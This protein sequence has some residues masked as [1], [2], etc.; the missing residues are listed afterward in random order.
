MALRPP[1]VKV[2]G[3]TDPATAASCGDL[4]VKAI[5]CVFYAK[6][7]R[8][9]SDALARE[10]CSALPPSIHR[11]GVFVDLSF[12]EIMHKAA[13]CGLTAAQLHGSEPPELVKRLK[14]E[15]ILVIK[16]LFAK[17]APGLDDAEDYA[18]GIF[19]VEQGKGAL[20]GGNAAEWDWG[21]LKGFSRNH[22]LI[23]AGGLKP[24]NVADAIALGQPDAVDVSSGVES[25]PGVKDLAS[26]EAFMTAVTGRPL[27]RRTAR[28]IFSDG[29]DR[30]L[31]D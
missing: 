11:V 9:V 19:L 7:P 1:Q 14:N 13:F 28:P 10:I 23:L 18:D 15:G 5:G 22:P 31:P 12:S 30:T 25:S 4:G 8:F 21:G 3:L 16:A 6:S 26:V 17:K 20:P 27:T 24:E 2:C 29:R